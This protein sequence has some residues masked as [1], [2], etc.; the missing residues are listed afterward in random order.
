MC[1][2]KLKAIKKKKRY[3]AIRRHSVSTFEVSLSKQCPV[4]LVCNLSSFQLEISIPI[5]FSSHFY[6]LVFVTLLF[7]LML[8]IF[9]DCCYN[10]FLKLCKLF[11]KSQYWYINQ[12]FNPGKFSVF[13]LTR[14]TWYIYVIS[15]IERLERIH[16][17]CWLVC[18]SFSLAH[19]KKG[20]EFLNIETAK[21]FKHL[22]RF[23]LQFFKC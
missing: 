7:G 5:F 9:T 4:I 17:F 21:V 14:Y 2:P 15:I 16:Q 20:S 10:S 11:L 6:H 8:L 19:S 22:I 12:I 13:T 3:D 1:Y 23:L 18:L